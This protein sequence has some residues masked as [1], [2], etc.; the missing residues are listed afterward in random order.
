GPWGAPGS[1]GAVPPPEDAGADHAGV[2]VCMHVRGHQATTA[3]MIVAVPADPAAGV[4]M[5]AALGNPCVSAY[6]PLGP[7]RS[8]PAVLGDASAWLRFARLRDRVDA[9]PDALGPVRA[10]LA[11]LEASFTGDP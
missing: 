11:P 2:T 7:D 4:R 10:V 6:V 9:D 1:T 8:V 3:S 5:W